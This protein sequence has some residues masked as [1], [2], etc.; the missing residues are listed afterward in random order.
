MDVNGN[1]SLQVNSQPKL[2][3]MISGSA[4]KAG[5]SHQIYSFILQKC[6]Y[7]SIINTGTGIIITTN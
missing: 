7:D 4:K 3:N 5:T 2:V 6:H 1:G